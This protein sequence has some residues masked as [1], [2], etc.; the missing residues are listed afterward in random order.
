[1]KRISLSF[2]LGISL[3]FVLGL[4]AP[5]VAILAAEPFEVRG[6][7]SLRENLVGY[8]TVVL[9]CAFCQFWVAAKGSRGLGAKWPTV[10]AMNAS[11]VMIVSM[12]FTETIGRFWAGGVPLLVSGCLGSL[13][14]A[15]IAEQRAPQPRREAGKAGA[16]VS[17]R[18]CR[19]SLLG[20]AAVLTVAALVLAFGVIPLVKAD[21][22]PMAIPHQAAAAFWVTVAFS[23]FAAAVLA[24]VTLRAAGR[25]RIST[26]ILGVPAFL[27][28]LLTFALFAPAAGFLGHGPAMR[29]A[30]V[31]LFICAA[32]DFFAVV[33]VTATAVAADRASLASG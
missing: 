3:S 11:L 25:D 15:F 20:G 23:L 32:A 17:L 12:F 8:L 5:F 16:G 33:L 21:L 6:Q 1:M 10:V 19:R 27:A 26:G 7:N 29:T 18:F 13:A 31:L 9:Y 22:S 24:F 14:G 4:L 30:S 28:F 2:V